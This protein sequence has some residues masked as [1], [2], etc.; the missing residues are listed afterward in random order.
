MIDSLTVI[1]SVLFVILSGSEE[2]VTSNR[3]S[4]QILHFVPLDDRWA[5]PPRMTSG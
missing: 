4:P 1:L 2:S 5:A 3:L